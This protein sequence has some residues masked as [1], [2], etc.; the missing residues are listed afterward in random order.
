MIPLVTSLMQAGLSILGGAVASKGKQYI[1]EKLNVDLGSLLATD[2]GK[3]ALARIE[4]EREQ[5]LMS[6]TIQ[7]KQLELEG[8]ALEHA[9]TANARGMQ[10][11]A[12]TQSDLF[13]KRFVY[14][15]A[16]VW[17]LG[18]MVYIGFITFGVIPE[19]NIR[20][21]DTILGF[22]LGTIVATILNFF[23]GSS[24]QSRAKD[25]AL[26]QAIKGVQQE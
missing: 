18:A 24:T 21:A 17:T 20:F 11:T 6:F 8:V 3:I 22:L 26:A 1:E 4:A 2:E 10:M 19:A 5:E 9:N 14:Y 25:E 23:F 13:A 7:K 15:L 12:L 16:G